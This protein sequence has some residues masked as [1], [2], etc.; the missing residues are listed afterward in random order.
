M[1]L[2][3]WLDDNEIGQADF[4]DRIGLTQGRISQIAKIGT[5]SLSTALLIEQATGGEV[6]IR[7]LMKSSKGSE[8]ERQAAQ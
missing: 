3:K 5:D 4:G 8:A 1:Q 7:D 2:S 6:S